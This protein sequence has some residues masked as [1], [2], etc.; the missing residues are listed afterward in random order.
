MVY[1]GITR[2]FVKIIVGAEVLASVFEYL[3]NKNFIMSTN[4]LRKAGRISAFVVASV[5]TMSSC[6]GG[7]KGS[8]ITPEPDNPVRPNEPTKNEA[9][10]PS[11]QK[12]RMEKI[13]KEV[14]GMTQASD[15]KSYSDLANY[16]YDTYNEDDYNWDGV[17]RWAENCWDATCTATGNKYTVNSGD[18]GKY[19]YSDYKALI[20]ASNFTGHFKASGGKW[21]RSDADD[22]QFS[23][24]GKNGENCVLKLE[25]NGNITKAYVANWEEYKGYDYDSGY[26]ANGNYYYKWTDYFNRVQGIVGVPENIVVTFTQGGKE[27][28][29]TSINIKLSGLTGEE[30]DISKGGIIISADIVLSNGYSINTSQ[31]N[32]A[33]NSKLSVASTTVKK[34]GT[35]IV[36]VAMSGDISGLPSCNVSAFSKENFDIDKY[37]TDDATAKNAFVKVDVLGKMQIQ[38]IVSNVRKYCDMLVKADENYEN[39]RNFKSYIDQANGLADVN[40]FY[41]NTATKQ[42]S[43]FMEAFVGDEWNGKKYWEFEPILKFY[44]GS[45][46]SP[47]GTYFNERDF[48]SVISIYKD[49]LAEFSDL[50]E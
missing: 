41:D 25:T 4:V 27:L 36:T 32:Y 28:V 47:F 2:K 43:V 23:F 9:L 13:A 26:D 46:N 18:Y 7:D 42:A 33:G 38:G 19:V 10:S 44:D 39:E 3:T 22:L 12:E 20:L 34:N 50:F 17:S 45:S 29:K 14:L 16:I 35:D 37:N 15:F 11:E 49:I 40:I 1:W 5:F 8:G 48:K 24:S 21:I 31:I 6:G 30:F